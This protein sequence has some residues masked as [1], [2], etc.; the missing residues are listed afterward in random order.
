MGDNVQHMSQTLI[1]IYSGDVE[2]TQSQMMSN[3]RRRGRDVVVKVNGSCFRIGSASGLNMNCL[4]D[5]LRQVVHGGVDCNVQDV[6]N[7]IANELRDV[8]PGAF[9]DLE[10]ELSLNGLR[11]ATR[12]LLS[13]SQTISR[14]IARTCCTSESVTSSG[15]AR[16]PYI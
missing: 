16:R 5:T 11:G 3:G 12:M 7:H 13:S 6:R 10:G 1:Q 2:C 8:M 15:A 4:I 14:S 9:L